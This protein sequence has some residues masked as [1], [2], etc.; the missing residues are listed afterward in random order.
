MTGVASGNV[1]PQ[2]AA[3]VRHLT[4]TDEREQQQDVGQLRIVAKGYS[5]LFAFHTDLEIAWEESLRFL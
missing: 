4:R 2:W 1:I 3:E 5:I